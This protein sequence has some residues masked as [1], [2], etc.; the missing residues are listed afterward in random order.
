MAGK[1]KVTFE[2]RIDETLYRKLL[3]AA[4]RDKQSLNNHMLHL[5]RTNVDY[6]ERIHGKIDASK[7]PLPEEE[8]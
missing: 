3:G 5:I 4:E 2:V 8:S 6:S 7:Y 1:N